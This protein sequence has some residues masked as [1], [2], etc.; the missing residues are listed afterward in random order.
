M[1]G[2]VVPST[3]I[4]A[5]RQLPPARDGLLG[6]IAGNIL[7]D[8]APVF[9]VCRANAA[10][11]Q[12][13]SAAEN[14]VDGPLD[15]AT[16]GANNGGITFTLLQD[17]APDWGLPSPVPADT[18]VIGYQLDQASN[19]P[20]RVMQL[21]AKVEADGQTT[22]SG[23]CLCWSIS[24]VDAGLTGQAL[25]LAIEAFVAVRDYPGAGSPRIGR[26]GDD[27]S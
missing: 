9:A 16:R 4:V 15:A 24:T 2:G 13:L 25:E 3:V 26:R 8:S 17:T 19:L 6:L 18:L 27:G 1:P 12:L 11:N 5:A 7:E 21:A 14:W 22:G 23:Q 10:R 20:G